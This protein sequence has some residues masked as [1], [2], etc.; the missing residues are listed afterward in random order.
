LSTP[1]LYQINIFTNNN[2]ISHSPDNAMKL[3][4]L[5][6]DFGFLPSTV[7]EMSNSSP[8]PI[9]RPRLATPNEEWAVTILSTHIAIDRNFNGTSIPIEDF[10]AQAGKIAEL[11]MNEFNKKGKRVS[12]ISK[13][14]FPEMAEDKLNSIYEIFSNPTNTFRESAPFEWNLRSV[15]RMNIDVADSN[16]EINFITN[17]GRIQG[18]MVSNGKSSD[19]DRISLDFDINTIA[20]NE[21]TRFSH[22][23]VSEFINKAHR[24]RHEAINEIEGIIHG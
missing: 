5:F 22:Q 8:G 23:A 2:D 4:S 13:T 10:L 11:F 12:L 3:M 15:R 20:E 17:V 9:L 16:E 7:H 18:N 19:F 14:M 24:L 21:N 6:R 1:I